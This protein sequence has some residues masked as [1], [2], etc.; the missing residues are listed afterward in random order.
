V[1]QAFY[2]VALCYEKEDKWE[3][4]K[5]QFDIVRTSFV[6]TDHAFEAALHIPDYYRRRGLTEQANKSF[7]E[8]VNYFNRYASENKSN[9]VAES[10]ALGFLVRA[11]SENQDFVSAAD[12]LALLHDRFPR[13]PEGKFAPLR[14]G[15]IYENTLCD[16]SKAVN[17]LKIFVDENPDAANIDDI[18]NHIQYLESK[19]EKV[20]NKIS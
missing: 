20:K 12:Q 15:D 11:Y 18:K 1:A 8:S 10:R 3:L 6:G 17:W 2:L 4:A 16:T 7:E 9:P 5:I 19:I 13:L 14:L